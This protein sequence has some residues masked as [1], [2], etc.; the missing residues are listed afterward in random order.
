MNSRNLPAPTRSIISLIIAFVLTGTAL[1]AAPV[2]VIAG[3]PAQVQA[4]QWAYSTL[5]IANHNYF[6]HRVAALKQIREAAGLLGID[7]QGDGP[8]KEDQNLSDTQLAQVQQVLEQLAPTLTGEDQKPVLEHL[9]Q[10]VKRISMA[11]MD[12]AID[13]GK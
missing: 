3:N 5:S 2:A 8:G 11:L 10:A 9:D 4:L 7:L 12:R 13:E 1:R 6:G